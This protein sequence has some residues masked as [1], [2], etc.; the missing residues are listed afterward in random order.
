MRHIRHALGGSLDLLASTSDAAALLR[1]EGWSEGRHPLQTA[2][3][4]N[5]QE[6]VRVLLE[7]GA[8]AEVIPGSRIAPLVLARSKRVVELL[9]EHGAG[10]Q[11]QG[12]RPDGIQGVLEAVLDRGQPVA[13]ALLAAGGVPDFET[14]VRLGRLDLARAV[15]GDNPSGKDLTMAIFAGEAELVEEL[16]KAG[17]SANAWVRDFGGSYEPLQAAAWA[18]EPQILKLLIEEG[19]KLKGQEGWSHPPGDFFC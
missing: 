3:D 7:A 6:V 15:V 13:E 17:V 12:G 4:R 1:G 18:D 10:P 5:H 14:A 16:L 2:V 19:A 11:L 9:V 8:S